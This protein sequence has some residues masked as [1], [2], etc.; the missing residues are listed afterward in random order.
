MVTTKLIAFRCPHDLV[1]ALSAQQRGQTKTDVIIEALRRALQQDS[2]Q[3][4]NSRQ[5]KTA[6]HD[7]RVGRSGSGN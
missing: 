7:M 5:Q 1:D 3:D 2:R 4:S 6:T